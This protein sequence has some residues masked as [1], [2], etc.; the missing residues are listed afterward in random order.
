[1][2]D[3]AAFCWNRS[4]LDVPSPIAAVTPTCGKVIAAG[5]LARAG[6][7][8][9]G[10]R[11]NARRATWGS[12]AA[13]VLGSFQSPSAETSGRKNGDQQQ[14]TFHSLDHLNF[15]VGGWEQR[16]PR[17]QADGLPGD[18]QPADNGSPPQERPLAARQLAG[19]GAHKSGHNKSFGAFQE[20]QQKT[21]NRFSFRFRWRALA[22]RQ[23]GR[24]AE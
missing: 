16:T 18:C 6:H 10:C 11:A 19:R 7:A 15:S 8:V 21:G 2:Q 14:T 12:H 3:S 5:R 9:I 13:A 17:L 22:P 4:A 23:S 20:V 1:V 24:D